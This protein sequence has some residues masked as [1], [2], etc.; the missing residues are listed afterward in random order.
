MVKVQINCWLS[1]WKISK[2]RKIVEKCGPPPEI[3]YAQHDGNSY[4]GQYELET[5]VHYNCV[6][7]YHRY[8][9]KGITIAKCLLNREK[10]AQWFGPDLRCRGIYSTF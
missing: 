6:P 8:N 7:G 9:N 4:S 1:G 3:P 2:A 5:E 10:A